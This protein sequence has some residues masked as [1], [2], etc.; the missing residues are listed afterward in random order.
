MNPRIRSRQR[1]HAKRFV[2]GLVLVPLMITA[3]SKSD[4]PQDSTEPRPEQSSIPTTGPRPTHLTTGAGSE[5]VPALPVP[6][7]AT[8]SSRRVV[9]SQ[10]VTLEEGQVL[11]AVAEYEVTNNLNT[12]IFVASMIVLTTEATSVTGRKITSANG[13]NVTPAMHHGQQTKNGTFQVTASD[14][15]VRYV[16]LVAW[17]ASTAATPGDAVVINPGYGR[18]SVLCW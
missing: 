13:Q 5:L 1:L 12:N 3:C 17:S 2:V 10:K 9:Y 16:N 4:S 18:L 6:A 11:L 15:G 14:A 7:R 8:A